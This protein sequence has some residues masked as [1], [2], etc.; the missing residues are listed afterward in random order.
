[1]TDVIIERNVAIPMRDGIA[2]Q[3]DIW[4]PND[5]QKHPVLLQRTPYDRANSFAVI[6]NAGIE[7][8]RAVAKGF[9]VAISDTRGR[10]GSQGTFDP[11]RTEAHDGYDTVQWLATRPYSNGRVGMYGASYY[12]ATQLLAATARPPALKAIAPQVTASDYHDTWTYQGG[13]LQLGFTLYW[14]L[15]LAAAELARR[16]KAGENL[17]AEA[18]EL[19]ELLAEPSRAFRIRPLTEIRALRALL[20]AWNQWL[21]HPSRDDYWRAVSIADHYAALDLPALHIGGWFD[22]FLRGTLANF[23][24]MS[25]TGA[26][27]RLII[28]PWAHAVCYDALGEVDYGPSA[29]AVAL[30]L[31]RVHLDWFAS[32]L[33]DG[34]AR[35][36]APAVTI[37]VMGA[38]TWRHEE[39]WPP[40]RARTH[41]WYLHRGTSGEGVLDTNLPAQDGGHTGYVYD[42]RNPVPTIGGAT[43]LPGV[44][45]GLNAGQRDQQIVERRPDVVTFTSPPLTEPLELCGPVTMV[46]YAAT[47]AADTD[48]TA[49]L[50]DVHPDG[51]A[52]N[53]CDGI[54][55]ARY[56]GGA[57]EPELIPPSTTAEFRI[58]LGAT[59]LL[60]EPGHA[61]RVEISSSNFPRFDAHPNVGKAVAEVTSDEAVVAQQQIWHSADQPSHLEVSVIPIE[62][63]RVT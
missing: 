11:F 20:P 8:L 1:M 19:A 49:K 25:T 38:N 51:R 27:Q 16:R 29:A 9:V 4:R 12:A 43:F 24:G 30:D 34:P 32:H 44:Y 63:E 23:A 56:R 35:Q 36:E 42:P 55:R 47:D 7:P 57:E 60:L 52:L 2:M 3:A 26:Q 39:T 33:A 54:A 17:D 46:L 21:A 62:K 5:G 14:A 6:V 50:V 40:K 18:E 41:R 59:S 61:L 13:A 10:F 31:T 53:V 45:V 28:G 48:W 37:F 58:D 22:L 15:G